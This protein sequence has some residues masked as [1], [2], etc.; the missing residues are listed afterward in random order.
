MELCDYYIQEFI[1]LSPDWNDYYQL[2][3]F[4]HLRSKWTNQINYKHLKKQKKLITKY[5]KLL[6]KKKEKSY[7]DDIFLKHLESDILRYKN[8]TLDY[9]PI[10]SLNNFPI[11][12]LDEIQGE[13]LYIFTNKQSYLDYLNRFKG[14]PEITNSVIYNMKKGIL[15]KDTLPKMIVLD[16]IDQYNNVLKSDINNIQ[17]PNFVKNEVIESINKYIIPS[18]K[19]IK[20]F[21]ETDYL[22]NCSEKIGLSSFSG[23]LSVYKSYVEEETMEGI[24]IKDIHNLGLREVKRITKKL[25]KIKNKM[26]FKGTLQEFYLENKKL[27][28]DNKEIIKDSKQIQ[29]DIY[30]NIYKKYFNLELTSNQLADIKIIKDKNSRQTPFY[31]GNKKKG[32]FYINTNKSLE[33]NKYELITLSL[34]ET[35]PGHHL[36]TMTHFNNNSIPL[37][38]KGGNY[39]GYVEGWGLYCENFT[40]IHS[41]KELVLKYLYEL[42]RSVRLV[43]D[44]G[45]NAY[46]WSYDKSFNYMKKHL[47]LS[48]NSIRNEILRYICNPAQA[49]SYKIGE[50]TILFLRDRYLKKY[51][52][53]IKGFHKLFFDIGPTSLDL[54]IKEF[55]KKNI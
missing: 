16:L 54:L 45:I 26:K 18:I 40:D 14:I 29:Q 51:P 2:D 6:K 1:K 10:D 5:Y 48:D 20:L 52:G 32:T 17:V 31:Q 35:I 49:L 15:K 41:D 43:V 38:I 13:T 8:I 24:S 3:Q 47:D 55:I 23:G 22:C 21:L 33:F 44:T 7:Y 11:Y 42:L 39:N 19:K 30:N 53:D 27:Y 9:L 28:N 34:H 25:I 36:Q 50:L 4:V 12:Y 37:Y 46:G